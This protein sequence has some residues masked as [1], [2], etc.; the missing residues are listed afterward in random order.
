MEN[1][2]LDDI[3]FDNRNKEYGAYFL[4]KNYKRHIVISL[5]FS[6][7]FYCSIFLIPFFVYES[8][9]YRDGT[10]GGLKYVQLTAEHLN[11]PVE[12]INLEQPLGMMSILPVIVDSK[13]SI[14]IPHVAAS[15]TIIFEYSRSDKSVNKRILDARPSFM[16]GDIQRF[17]NWVVTL[18]KFPEEAFKNKIQ[19]TF[20]AVFVIE[21]DGS[22]SN[23]KIKENVDRSIAR[24]MKRVIASSPKW[25]PGI[26][27][28]KPVRVRCS[29]FLTFGIK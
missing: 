16:G 15:D 29:T 19:G 21:K 1:L 28:G 14:E 22:L 7:I 9:I 10:P 18:I 6:V 5:I 25:S 26:V 17:T 12:K 8:K 20:E 11:L 23:I 2:N 27:S 3:V 4:R 13:S 24:E